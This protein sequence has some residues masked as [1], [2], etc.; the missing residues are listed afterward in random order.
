MPLTLKTDDDGAAVLSEN[1]LPVFTD[2]DG[3]DR[4]FDPNQMHSKI[5]SN[6]AEAK[7]FRE[8]KK[9]LSEKLA[10]FGDIEDLQEYRQRADEAMNT[11]Q[12]LKDK[13]LVKAGEVDKL[14]TEMRAGFEDKESKL[15]Q[16]F[17]DRERELTEKLSGKD[18]AI[19]HLMVSNRFATSP[20][21]G[22]DD[23]KTTLPP[24]IAET[25]FGRYFEVQDTDGRLNVVAKDEDGEVILSREKIGEPAGFN[26][27][28]EIIF[29]RYPGRDKLLRASGG[30]SGSGGGQGSVTKQTPLAKL[31]SAYEQAVKDGDVTQQIALRT[32]IHTATQEQNN[33][34]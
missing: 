23:P 27:A 15:K 25:Y 20:L 9:A 28:I 19:R 4:I 14:K 30:G 8:E 21:F 6:G 1:G 13:D 31:K 17:A 26:E 18:A 16:Q 33:R 11:V 3:K 32:R 22:G 24:D 10:V 29:D 2:D 5:L 12:N 34:R 7:K